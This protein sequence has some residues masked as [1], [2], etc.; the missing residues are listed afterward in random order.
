M[1]DLINNS[2]TTIFVVGL[3]LA[4]A[5]GGWLC[6]TRINCNPAPKKTTTKSTTKTTTTKKKPATKK[7]PTTKKKS[8]KK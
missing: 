2:N 4:V 8:T 5:L 7:K 1:L 3:I 6:Y